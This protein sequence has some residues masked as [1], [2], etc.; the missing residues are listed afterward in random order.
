MTRPST[1]KPMTTATPRWNHSIQAALS[2]IGGIH[3]PRQG[4]QSGQP[5]PELVERTI[6]PM[7]TNRYVIAAVTKARRSK[8][9][10]RVETVIGTPR[11]VRIGG[12]ETPHRRRTALVLSRS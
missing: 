7:T 5:M 9:V 3:E 12:R 8:V 4:G 10:E 1:R 11:I 6:A 2:P